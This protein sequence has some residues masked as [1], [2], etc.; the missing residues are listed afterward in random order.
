[1]IRKIIYSFCEWI[2]CFNEWQ[3]E[4]YGAKKW[5]YKIVRIK[6]WNCFLVD[7]V[8]SSGIITDRQ[9]VCPVWNRRRIKYLLTRRYD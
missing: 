2:C 5:Q 1:M 9:T 4:Y 3:E 6:A 7:K 8:T